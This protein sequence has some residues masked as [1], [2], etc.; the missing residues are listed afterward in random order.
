MEYR[1][2]KIDTDLRNKINQERSEDKIH[3]KKGI[4]INKDKNE[5]KNSYFSLPDSKKPIMKDE[6]ANADGFSSKEDIIEPL[7]GHFIDT[8]K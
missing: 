5:E 7:K 4:N 6:N 3:N 1:I 8:R 2:N